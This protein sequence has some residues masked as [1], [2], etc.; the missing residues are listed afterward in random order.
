MGR[1]DP[2]ES[3]GSDVGAAKQNLRGELSRA[4]VAG[5]AFGTRLRRSAKT[6][7][8][9]RTTPELKSQNACGETPG[10]IPI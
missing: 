10:P 8:R 1:V 2:T 7:R 4:E 3:P 9:R 5:T 6:T